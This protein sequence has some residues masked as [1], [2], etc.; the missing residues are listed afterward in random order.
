M[1]EFFDSRFDPNIV[2]EDGQSLLLVAAGSDQNLVEIV[3]S[4]VSFLLDHGADINSR[5]LETG[6]TPILALCS[7]QI[8]SERKTRATKILIENGANVFITCRNNG[9]PLEKS[10]RQGRLDVVKVFLEYF[11]RQNTPFHNIQNMVE[12]AVESSDSAEIRKILCRFYWPR[13]Y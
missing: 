12:K 8:P 5:N 10:A 3:E 4:T 7:L 6:M 11:N 13:V 1:R 2:R 9:F